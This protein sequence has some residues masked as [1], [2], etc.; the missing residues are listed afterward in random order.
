MTKSCNPEGVLPEPD[1]RRLILERAGLVLKKARALSA[2]LDTVEVQLSW[3]LE[4]NDGDSFN[5]FP[6]V[7]TAPAPGV[8]MSLAAAA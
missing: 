8:G 6:F 2:S 1:E 5:D 7:P 4:K 3:R